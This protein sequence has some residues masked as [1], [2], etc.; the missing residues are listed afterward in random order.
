[1]FDMLL[2]YNIIIS[3]VWL[4]L[5][6]LYWY[7]TPAD[8]SVNSVNSVISVVQDFRIR[9]FSLH[10][11]LHHAEAGDPGAEGRTQVGQKEH[12]EDM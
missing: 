10:Q 1:M 5:L 8:F 3:P 11:L 4:F 6:W 7:S 2:I 12:H 9:S